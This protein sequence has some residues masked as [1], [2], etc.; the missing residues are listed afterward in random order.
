MGAESVKNF[1]KKYDMEDIIFDL[2]ES[3]ATV[4][5]AAKTIGIEPKF[6]AKTL[7]FRLK[8]RDVLIV[9]RGDSRVDN[10]KFRHLFKTKAKMLDHDELEE[11]TGQPVG[12]LCPFG[13]KTDMDIYVDTSIKDFEYV[14]PAAGSRT[15]A[16]KI[17]PAKIQELTNAEWVDI[18]KE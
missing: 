16:M 17:S 18:S 1:L 4:D 3:G 5:M 6:V 14:Y 9:L 8:D 10:K 2:D 7:A 11:V 13:L 12:G 15:K